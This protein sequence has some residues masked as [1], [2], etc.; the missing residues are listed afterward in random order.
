MMFPTTL[1]IFGEDGEGR[2]AEGVHCVVHLLNSRATIF[3]I[4]AADTEQLGMRRID[5]TVIWLLR[6]MYFSGLHDFYFSMI[7]VAS[8]E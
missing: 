4:N 3:W 2:E 7:K 1:D 6:A 8:F 5:I